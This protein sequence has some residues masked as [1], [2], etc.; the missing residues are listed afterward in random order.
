MKKKSA[1]YKISEIKK[2]NINKIT[3]E[4][5]FYLIKKENTYSI[6][7]KLDRKLIYEYLTISASSKK[8]YL[9]VMK[10]KQEIVGYILYAKSEKELILEFKRMKFKIIKHLLLKLKFFSI[11]NILL[12]ISK[13]DILLANFTFKK[14]SPGT[15][16]LNLLAIKKE[17]QSKGLGKILIKK[18]LKNLLSQGLK[19]NYI[20]CEAPTSRAL[21]FY[22]RNKFILLGKKIRL[23][24]NLFLL[25]KKINEF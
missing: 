12:A 24:K 21:K 2:K 4:K 1:S 3:L 9:F 25:K 8:I 19:L 15:I 13:L 18:S 5:I 10:S 11:I 23:F 22:R 17:Y 7:S 6:L 14:D 16:N 20:S